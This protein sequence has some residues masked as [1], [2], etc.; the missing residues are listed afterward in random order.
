MTHARK[1][2][3]DKPSFA[4]TQMADTETTLHTSIL[5]SETACV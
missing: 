1:N 3:Q 4:G 5:Q 2:F